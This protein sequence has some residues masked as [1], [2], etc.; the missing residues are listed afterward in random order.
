MEIDVGGTL[1]LVSLRRALP[2]PVVPFMGIGPNA[3]CDAAGLGEDE[4]GIQTAAETYEHHDHVPAKQWTSYEFLIDFS[5]RLS[6]ELDKVTSEKSVTRKCREIR[7]HHEI[8]EFS[9]V[10]PVRGD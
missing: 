10:R 7:I 1:R 6:V 8:V 9:R 5:T 3:S 2:T 4:A